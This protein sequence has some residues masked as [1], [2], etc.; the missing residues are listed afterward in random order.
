MKNSISR[1]MPL[2]G[3]WLAL[4]LTVLLLAQMAFTPFA[5]KAVSA[6]PA[7][8]DLKI[9]TFDA[10]QDGSEPDLT[11]WS[12]VPIE[13]VAHAHVS[14]IGE[15][16][17]NVLFRLS[18]PKQSEYIEAVEFLE[19]RES[20]YTVRSED[21]SSWFVEYYVDDLADQTTISAP[22]SL[23]F[24]NGAAPNGTTVTPTWIL[25]SDERTELASA[26]A[27]F[28]AKASTA[29]KFSMQASEGVVKNVEGQQNRERVAQAT[30]QLASEQEASDATHTPAEGV[31]VSYDFH[32]IP[33]PASGAPDGAGQ[34]FPS[35]VRFENTLA[36]GVELAPQSI[37]EGWSVQGNKAV[38]S[39]AWDAQATDT[40]GY[41]KRI[42][43]L[44]KN[45]AIKAPAGTPLMHQNVGTAFLTYEGTDTMVSST[46]TAWAEFRAYGP[47]AA[48]AALQLEKT[49]KTPPA[50]LRPRQPLAGGKLHPRA[51]FRPDQVRPE[52]E[53]G[54]RHPPGQAR[55]RPLP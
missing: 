51:G 20:S 45:V 24:R 16:L 32:V 15:G 18:I 38:F 31:L 21:E 43:L 1:T 28:T 26:T 33:D 40:R 6:A 41:F 50:D 10:L 44:Y 4:A 25:L 5:A 49:A 2:R 9:T 17:Q 46:D 39:D 55:L 47:P 52:L 37:Q 8:Y 34:F 11:G 27:T 35:M 48:P 13:A 42:H 12:G 30:F 7:N 23:T 14:G 29:Y 22:F 36:E 3:A 19:P 53:P 54:R